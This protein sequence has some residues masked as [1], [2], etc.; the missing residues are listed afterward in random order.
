MFFWCLTRVK[1][2]L[3]GFTKKYFCK[4]CQSLWNA[5]EENTMDKSLNQETYNRLKRD[6]LTFAL[7]PGDAV[8]AAKLAERYQVSRTPVREALVKLETEGMVNI[9][10]QSKTVISKIN[11]HRVRQEWFIRKTLELGMVDSFFEKMTDSDINLMKMYNDEIAAC[12]SRPMSPD[13]EF[14]YQGYDNDF[15]GVMYMAAGERLSATIICFMTAHYNRLRIL[16]DREE[17]FKRRTLDDHETL[18]ECMKKRDKEGF[19]NV[20]GEHL[21]HI[22]SD[23]DRVREMYPDYIEG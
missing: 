23:M 12:L 2:M 1:K 20:L 4:G 6:I 14:D 17:Q 13:E 10:P 8:S 16:I 3:D 21:S 22:I 19:R 11:V 18:M 15:H 5:C 9:F 7:K